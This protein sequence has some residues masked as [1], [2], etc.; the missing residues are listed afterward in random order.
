MPVC[1]SGPY[2]EDPKVQRQ[3]TDSYNDM[4][5]GFLTFPLKFPG[6]QVWKAMKVSECME[7]CDE[8]CM[9][10]ILQSVQGHGWSFGLSADKDY[11]FK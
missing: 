3:F 7:Q 5:K 1:C 11:I 4:A 8:C 10:C 9:L 6:T 2:L